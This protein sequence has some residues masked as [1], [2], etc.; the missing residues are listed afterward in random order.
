MSDTRGERLRAAWQDTERPKLWPNQRP[1]DAATL[2]V[3]DRR[4]ETPKLL[5]GRRH[6]GHKFMPGKFVFPGGRLERSDRLMPSVSDLTP[7]TQAR[8]QARVVRPTQSRGRA[9]ALTAIRE[10]YEETGLLLG[11]PAGAVALPRGLDPMWQPFAAAGVLPDLAALTFVARA[12]TPPRR[13]KRFDTRFFAVDR[14]AIRSE[15][16]GF[17]GPDK[18]LVELCWVDLKEAQALDLPRITS[19][20]LEELEHRLAGGF[21]ADAAVPFYREERGRFLRDLL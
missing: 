5:M 8:L 14:E 11:R 16:D 2:I 9:L 13:P 12:I 15:A 20:V 6:D 7:E 17:V 21:P 19:I 10:T 18:E 4:R 3:I 1:R